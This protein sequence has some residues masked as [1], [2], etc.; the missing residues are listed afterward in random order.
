DSLSF[1]TVLLE[2]SD[3]VFDTPDVVTNDWG[4]F[5]QVVWRL[6]EPAARWFVGIRGDLVGPRNAPVPTG[7][8]LTNGILTPEGWVGDQYMRYR[9]SPDVTFYPSEFS[10]LRLQYNYDQPIGIN[11]QHMV[12]LQFEFL[13]GAHGAH[14][15]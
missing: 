2:A 13:M 11:A 4:M 1:V 7:G 15:F 8:Y 10:K 14:K 12:A 3:R 6:P 9:I 5:A